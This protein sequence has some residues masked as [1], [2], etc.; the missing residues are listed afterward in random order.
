MWLRSGIPL[1]L[2][3]TLISWVSANTIRDVSSATG[4][5]WMTLMPSR[6]F[7]PQVE[8]TLQVR[9]EQHKAELEWV[10]VQEESTTLMEEIE[11]TVTLLT[12]FSGGFG[13][14]EEEDPSYLRRRLECGLRTPI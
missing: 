10:G 8:V 11:P 12:G 1:A 7:L 14:D 13:G 6:R 5:R 9:V 4:T 3:N 2:L